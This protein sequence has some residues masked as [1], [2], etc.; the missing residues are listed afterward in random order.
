MEDP[1]ILKTRKP[2]IGSNRYQRST[3][4]NMD[5]GML[6]TSHQRENCGLTEGDLLRTSALATE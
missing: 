1:A 4:A 3:A 6:I 5:A 2:E